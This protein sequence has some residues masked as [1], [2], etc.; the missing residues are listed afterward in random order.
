MNIIK[1]KRLIIQVCHYIDV[2]PKITN[3]YTF[4]K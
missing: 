1:I 2:M 4:A 3:Y